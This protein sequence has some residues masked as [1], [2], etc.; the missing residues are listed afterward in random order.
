MQVNFIGHA[1]VPLASLATLKTLNGEM[2]VV[3]PHIKFMFNTEYQG[4]SNDIGVLDAVITQNIDR[5]HRAA[6]TEKVIEVHG[7]IDRCVC[8]E[9]GGRFPLEQVVQALRYVDEGHARGK[10]VVIP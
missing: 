9:C 4:A 5:L 1:T 3:T 2:E 7:S 8:L 10:V 6:G